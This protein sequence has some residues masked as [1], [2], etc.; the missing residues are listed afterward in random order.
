MT[1]LRDRGQGQGQ[2]TGTGAG[3]VKKAFAACLIDSSKAVK[4]TTS[5]RI[6]FGSMGTSAIASRIGVNGFIETALIKGWRRPNLDE[7]TSS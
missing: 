4:V 5:F 3:Q 1:R 2:G 7:L 6:P